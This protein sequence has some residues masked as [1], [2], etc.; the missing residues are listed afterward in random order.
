MRTAKTTFCSLT[1]PGPLAG[2]FR[3]AVSLH[4]HTLH[5][6]EGMQFIPRVANRLAPLKFAIDHAAR[7]R[8]STGMDGVDWNRIWWTPPLT[9]RQALDLEESQIRGLGLQ[10]LVSLT[11]HDDISA[12]LQLSALPQFSGKI[13]ISAE[14]TVPFGETFFH[15][16]VH[17]LPAGEATRIWAELAAATRAADSAL[18][19]K[20]LAMVHALP[21]TLVVLNHP[22]WDEKG[23]G[24]ARHKQ[25]LDTFM[26]FAAPHLDALELNGMRPDAENRAVLA[27]AAGRG[28]PV[29]S[30]GDRHGLEANSCLNLTDADSFG[31]FATELRTTGTSRILLMPNYRQ[32][33][34][35][36]VIHHLWEILRDEPDHGLG[37]VRWDDRVF[38]RDKAGVERSLREI[39]QNRPP[40]IVS[41]FVGLV[42]LMGHA[43]VRNAVRAALSSAEQESGL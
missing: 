33:L 2:D 6:R 40:R 41:A 9:P 10:P 31:A 29:V 17:N 28:I 42:K 14:W 26:E 12:P 3:T 36:R 35:L 18:L 38:Y 37:W 30:G 8:G 16:G 11:D 43:P 25:L 1:G 7:R 23:I 13:P 22:C 24:L 15:V 39:W 19:L 32:G 34:T 4:G 5:S 20:G 21:E 27:Y